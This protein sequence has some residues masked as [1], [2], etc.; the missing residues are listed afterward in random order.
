M[1]PALYFLSFAGPCAAAACFRPEYFRFLT[2]WTLSLHV[3]A[4]LLRSLPGVPCALRRFA[5]GCSVVGAM[6]VLIGYASVGF[7][8]VVRFGSWS[9]WEHALN[10]D[11]PFAELVA[12]KS[13]EHLWPVLAVC[14]DVKRS[15]SELHQTYA[16]ASAMGSLALALVGYVALGTAWEK[17]CAADAG[18]TLTIYKQPDAFGTAPILARLGVAEEAAAA[19][20]A[21]FIFANAQKL[22]MVSTAA[23]AYARQ[24][25]PLISATPATAAEAHAPARRSPRR[26]AD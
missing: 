1:W 12:M 5:H 17:T 21:D 16:G 18:D 13:Y 19:L 15:R 10:G 4:A 23:I 8:G 6:S 20:P 9:A 11:M 7:G 3:T 22:L 2:Y 14:I 26:K 25:W 24:V